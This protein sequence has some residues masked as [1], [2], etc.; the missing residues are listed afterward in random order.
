VSDE[1]RV[2]IDLGAR[3]RRLY[4]RLRARVAQPLEPGERSR[5]RDLLLLIPD[6]S[7]LLARLAKDPRVPRGG[8][9][10]A[11]LALAYVSSPIDLVPEFLGPIGF[12]DD[13][14]VLG[15]ALSRMLNYVHPDVVRSH[16]SGHGDVLDTIHKVSEWSESLVRDNLPRAIR[17]LLP[18]FGGSSADARRG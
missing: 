3:E 8:K 10:I 17:R 13:A 2:E 11:L 7:V 16:W 6:L 5:V 15:A 14:L 9:V 4:D 12:L 18:G 1:E